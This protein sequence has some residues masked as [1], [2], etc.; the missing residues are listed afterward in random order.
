MRSDCD[1]GEL[2]FFRAV[3]PEYSVCYR[4]SLFCIGLKDFLTLRTLKR[5]EFMGL[6]PRMSG[7]VGQEKECLLYSLV[8]LRKAPVIFQALKLS[9]GLVSKKDIEQKAALKLAEIELGNLSFGRLFQAPL[10]TLKCLFIS[11]KPLLGGRN[12]I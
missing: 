8:S 9:L 7:I 1:D 12:E 3:V 2:G 5:S 10:N 6:K 11:V 4:S